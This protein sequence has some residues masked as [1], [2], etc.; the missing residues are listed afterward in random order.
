[1]KHIVGGKKVEVKSCPCCGN[2]D[3]YLGHES[4]DTMAV[5]CWGHGGGCGLRVPVTFPEYNKKGRGLQG[6]E[7]DCLMKAVEKWNRRES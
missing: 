1:M 2:G 4:F 7:E 3:L 5:V 6:I